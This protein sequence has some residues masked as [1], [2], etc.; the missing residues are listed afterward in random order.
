[1]R[2]EFQENEKERESQLKLKEM[3]L[4]MQLKMK[5]LEIRGIRDSSGDKTDVPFDVSKHIRFVPIFSESEVDKYFL[6]FEKVAQSLK[7]PKE[8]WTL[9]LQSSLVGKAREIYSAL[10]IEESCQYEVV[11]AAVLKVYELVPEA[12]RQKFRDTVKRG[13]QTYV[14]FARSKETLFDRWCASKEIQEDF[15]KLRQLVLIEEFKKCL[16]NEVK[17]YIDEKKVDI[18]NQAAVLADDYILTHKAPV[19]QG[20]QFSSTLNRHVQPFVP[21]NGGGRPANHRGNARN[22]QRSLCY[23]LRKPPTLPAGPE[24]FHCHK[25]GHVM[26]DCW[27]LRGTNQGKSTMTTVKVQIPCMHESRQHTSNC[28]TTH[29]D[30]YRPFVSQGYIYLPGSTTKTPILILRDTGANQSLLLE[31]T[32]P[33]SEQSLRAE[34]LIHGVGLE[35]ISVPLHEVGLQSDIVSGL[36]EV[37]IRPSLPIEG[38]SLILGNDLAGGK[39]TVDPY[40]TCQ[41]ESHDGTKEEVTI[42]PACGVTRAMKKKAA[43]KDRVTTSPVLTRVGLPEAS[44]SVTDDL[45]EESKDSNENDPLVP[46]SETFMA[47]EPKSAS[48]LGGENPPVQQTLPSNTNAMTQCTL[49]QLQENDPSLFGVLEQAVSEAEA[50]ARAVLLQK[51]W[52]TDEKVEPI[53]HAGR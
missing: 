31:G 18:L 13:D 27:H 45:E 24:C 11:K 49:I 47:H 6:H 51:G 48:N 23:H 36:V 17:T 41:P 9:L 44:G 2:L 15:E 28:V 38:I 12:Y 37:E 34:V 8:L 26:A 32:L 1:M 21:T 3:E 22:S 25:M 20:T 39:V 7:W 43:E 46:L 19:G 10:S 42:Y 33:L 14:E 4:N 53:G 16:P 29:G 30:G 40:M 52:N 5:E 50:T 35:P